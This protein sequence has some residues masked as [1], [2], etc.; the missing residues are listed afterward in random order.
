MLKKGPR[1]YSILQGICG[2][3]VIDVA[4]LKQQNKQR[5]LTINM[6][7]TGMQNKTVQWDYRISSLRASVASHC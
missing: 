3:S 1:E 7:E 5:N 6:K 4:V 2:S